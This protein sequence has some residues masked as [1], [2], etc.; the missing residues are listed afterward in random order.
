[1]DKGEY[2]NQ[3]IGVLCIL[4]DGGI[5]WELSSIFR[6]IYCLIVYSGRLTGCTALYNHGSVSCLISM[7]R[8]GWIC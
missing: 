6:F 4:L 7:L 5:D 1:M 3:F 8:D 2:I